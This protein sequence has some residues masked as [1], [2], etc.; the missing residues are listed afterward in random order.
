MKKI[1]KLMLIPAIL[2]FGGIANGVFA[3]GETCATAVAVT[4]GDYIADGPATGGGASNVCWGEGGTNADWYSFTPTTDMVILIE[5]IP[6]DIDTRLSFYDGDCASLNCIASNDDYEDSG[7]SLITASVTAGTTYY[8][9][10][11]DPYDDSSFDWILSE[12]VVPDNDDC[13]DAIAVVCGDVISGTTLGASIDNE[14]GCPDEIFA[15]GVWYTFTGTGAMVSADVC[16]ADYDTQIY[17][18]TGTCGSL[19]CMDGNDDMCGDGLQSR[20]DWFAENGTTYYI[21]V[22]GYDVD[23]GTFDLSIDCTSPVAA[24]WIGGNGDYFDPNPEE[25][26]FSSDNWDV[27]DVPGATTDVSIP[28][29]S[30]YYPTINR[31]AVCSNI[32]LFS[33]AGDFDETATLIDDGHLTVGETATMQRYYA[34]GGT[35]FEEWHLIG[36]PIS[37]ARAGIYTDYYLQW[38]DE[39]NVEWNDIELETYP[40]TPLQ[41]FAFYAPVDEM[42]FDYEG[43]FGNGTYNISISASGT[44]PDGYHWNLFGNPYPSS[45]DWDDVISVNGA[46]LAL[47]AV[48]YLDQSTGAYLSYS[49]GVGASRYVPPGQGFFVAGANDGAQFTV[50]NTMRSHTNG[51]TYYKSEFENLLVLEATGNGYSDAA[52]LRFD[53]GAT[54]EIDKQFDAVKMFTVTNPQLPQLYT[55]GGDKLSINVLP[56]TEMVPAGFKAGVPGI[57]TININEVTGMANVILEDIETNTLTDLMDNAYTFNYSLN[58]PEGRFIVHFTPLAVPETFKELVNIFS[59]NSDIYVTVPAKTEGNIFVYN[60]I[61]QEIASKRIDGSQNIIT[62]DKSS[63]YIVKVLSNR[64]IITEKIFIK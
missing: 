2:L 36:A 40:L 21:L 47:N 10:W 15:P 43:I 24:S 31:T 37:D 60:M 59:F 23:M 61:G 58:D 42:T 22:H 29:G 55:V 13:I 27:E 32:V 12:L 53:E 17:I 50:D 3:Q 4:L 9:E 11:D 63:Y 56:E 44:H 7:A 35:T 49:A 30:D 8:I 62:L 18:Y 26:W 51:S 38:F 34:T 28:A 19:T 54:N 39:A 48:Y 14:V 64:N 52:Y 45:L 25:D 57:Y 46:N 33:N 41:G 16:N 5:S 1:T 20:V 6:G